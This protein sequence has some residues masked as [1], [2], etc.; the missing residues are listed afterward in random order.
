LKH[1]AAVFWLALA[2]S[3][4]ALGADV[5]PTAGKAAA[6]GTASAAA[7]RATRRHLIG[8]WRLVSIDVAGPQG[9]LPDPFY[10]PESTG[11]IVYDRSGWMSVQIAGPRRKAWM[12]P[13]NRDADTSGTD[14]RLKAAAF[15]SY[16]AYYG[17]WR[18]DEASSVVVHQVTSSLIPAENGAHYAQTAS[19][20]GKGRLILASTDTIDGAAVVR[21]KVWQRIDLSAAD[22][23]RAERAR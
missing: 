9:P 12:A 6:T 23:T 15:D 19:I 13:A 8:A 2:C 16:Y 10:Q 1:C 22:A 20:D 4:A 5:S 17:T 7:T 14:A 18:L 21:T 11:C 3:C